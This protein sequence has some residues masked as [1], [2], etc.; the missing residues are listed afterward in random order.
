[1]NDCTCDIDNAVPF[2]CPSAGQSIRPLATLWYC[3]K[4]AK[5]PLKFF[6]GW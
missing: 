1:M 4:T 3:V 6:S 2:V 5:Q